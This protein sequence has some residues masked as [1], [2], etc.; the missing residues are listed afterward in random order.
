MAL[1]ESQ[2]EKGLSPIPAKNNPGPVLRPPNLALFCL[3]PPSSSAVGAR[4]GV[5]GLLRFCDPG[6]GGAVAAGPLRVPGRG[7]RV[8]VPVCCGDRASQQPGLETEVRESV[9]E[10]SLSY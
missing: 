6:L 3:K 2:A 8:C 4:A 7:W 10:G 9:G 1:S 5:E